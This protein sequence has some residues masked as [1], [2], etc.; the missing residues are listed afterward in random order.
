[1]RR[2]DRRLDRVHFLAAEQPVLA[3]VRIE[4]GHREMRRL[5][6]KLAQRLRAVLDAFQRALAGDLPTRLHQ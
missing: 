2:L 6:A 3:A 4:R 5:D 1:M